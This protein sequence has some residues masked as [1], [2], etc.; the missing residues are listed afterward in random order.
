MVCKFGESMLWV[1]FYF[2]DLFL[3]SGWR[4]DIVSLSKAVLPV[5]PKN[6]LFTSRMWGLFFLAWFIIMK[7]YIPV[8]ENERNIMKK[9]ISLKRLIEHESVAA[10][11]LNGTL[12]GGRSVL[13]EERLRCISREEYARDEEGGLHEWRRD[14]LYEDVEGECEFAFYGMENQAQS[15][16]I[17]PLRV[18]GVDLSNY[19]GQV[20]KLIQKNKEEK[21]P[22]FASTIH[23]D[24][25][26]V[27]VITT[28]INYGEP[29]TGPKQLWDMLNLEEKE[30]MYPYL[31]NYR[32]NLVELKGN[33]EFYKRFHSDFRYVAQYLGAVGDRAAMEEFRRE[34]KTVRFVPEFLDVMRAISSDKRYEEVKNKIME[35][36]VQKEE[37]AVCELLDMVEAAGMEKGMEEGKRYTLVRLVMKHGD[38]MS[39]VELSDFMEVS[40][41]FVHNIK[42]LIVDN[43]G[44]D[45]KGICE[46]HK[47]K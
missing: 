19:M 5:F 33:R 14:A 15:D 36:D 41:E 18:A 43:P 47:G 29:W 28:V 20:R 11:I 16:N 4:C 12:F 23:G 32:L 21:R 34:T 24:Q 31:L 6:N 45:A 26:L 7:M 3:F 8:C 44:L 40:R 2:V 46:L 10:D 25:K 38:R 35:S 27:P 1:G 17:M 39:D 9:D 37:T 30:W 22:A 13:R 42:K